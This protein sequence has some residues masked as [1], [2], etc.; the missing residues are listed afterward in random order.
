MTGL[1]VDQYKDGG[2]K[3]LDHHLQIRNS[4]KDFMRKEVERKKQELVQIYTDAKEFVDKSNADIHGGP[5]STFSKQW[6]K[7]QDSVQNKITESRRNFIL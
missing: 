2:S 7:D 4:Q 6:K 5:V 1:V 3:L